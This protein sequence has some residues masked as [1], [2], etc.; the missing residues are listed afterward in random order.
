MVWRLND[1]WP[2]I[3]W[4]VIDYYLQPKIAYY[5]LRRCFSPVLVCFERTLDEVGVWV[6]NDSSERVS[7][8]LRVARES[9]GGE[10]RG[11]AVTEV[12]VGSGEAVRALVV[13][14]LGPIA[15]REEFLWGRFAGVEATC[16]LKEERYLHLPVAKLEAKVVDGS[17][18]VRADAFA[19]GVEIDLEE[20]DG[21]DGRQAFVHDNYFDLRAGA[22]VAVRVDHVRPGSEVIVKAVNA[23]AVV[24]GVGV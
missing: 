16:L 4:S 20:R 3:Y 18:L 19:R 9:F 5:F 24:A 22:S 2:I 15:L 8:E 13:N 6:V 12:T 11:E 17:V 21:G 23:N 10:V 1:S 14:E 7:G